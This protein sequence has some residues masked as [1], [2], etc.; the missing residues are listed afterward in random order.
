MQ[1]LI[2]QFPV[3]MAG[4]RILLLSSQEHMLVLKWMNHIHLLNFPLK[5]SFFLPLLLL[6]F[7]QLALLCFFLFLYLT[8][9]GPEQP[10]FP[11][12]LHF[13]EPE[14]FVVFK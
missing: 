1:A 3:A 4:D 13:P 11:L 10:K 7:F 5:I 6:S 12:M 14:W 9:L 8:L 2:W